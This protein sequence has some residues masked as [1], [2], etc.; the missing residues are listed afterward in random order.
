MPINSEIKH[1]TAH[2]EKNFDDQ[3]REK[4]DANTQISVCYYHHVNR[5]QSDHVNKVSEDKENKEND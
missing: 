3:L 1:A 4:V 5:E 2:H